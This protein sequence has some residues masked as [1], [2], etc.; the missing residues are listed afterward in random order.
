MGNVITSTADVLAIIG[1]A[2][3]L[4]LGVFGAIRYSRCRSVSCCCSACVIEN[5][6]PTEQKKESPAGEIL[7]EQSVSV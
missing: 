7:R 6:P 4:V 5:G 3:T 2:T 1:G